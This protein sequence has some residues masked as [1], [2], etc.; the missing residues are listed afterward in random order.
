MDQ[1]TYQTRIGHAHL[2]VRDLDRAIDFYTHFFQL[3]V[4]EVVAG[5]YGARI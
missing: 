2:K 5:H 4:I 3:E 1:T